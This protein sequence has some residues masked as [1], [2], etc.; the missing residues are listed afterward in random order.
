MKENVNEKNPLLVTV[1]E[2][3]GIPSSAIIK[4]IDKLESKGH[5]IHSFIMV[6]NGKIAAEGY[7]KP[8]SPDRKHR[9]YSISKSFVS[10][11][12]GLM[13]EEGLLSLDDRIVSF[14]PGKL[15]ADGV[16][17]YIEKM[18][19]RDLLRM[20]SA[21]EK[22]TY[23]IMKNDDWLKTFFTVKPSHLPGTVF[24]YDTSAAHT[25]GAIVEQLSGMTI[26]DYMRSRFLDFIGFSEDA[27][28]LKCPMGISQGGS[29]LVCT[30]RDI[31]K[32]ALTCMHNGQFDGRQLIPEK[33]IKAAT[34]RQIDSNVSNRYIE[35]QQGYGYLFWRCRNNGFV[36]LGMGGQLAICLPDKDFILVTTADT[37]S[38]SDEYSIFFD[39][40]WDEIYPYLSEE[41]ISTDNTKYNELRK[42]LESL[43][44]PVVKGAKSTTITTDVTNC[45]YGFSDNEL[46]LSWVRFSFHGDR[47]VFEYIN[48]EGK[49]ELN[50]GLGIHISQKFPEINYNCIT[51]AAWTDD[52]SLLIY[53]YIIDDCLATLKIN[54]IFTDDSITIYMSKF[55]E[56]FLEN[57]SGC[58]SGE[59]L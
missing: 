54:V 29:G 42:K 21:H 28:F 11:A 7:W 41:S 17:P 3:V 32:F 51:S 2:E 19:I 4:F 18:K 56:Q 27:F 31:A 53:S 34:S 10:V 57:Y 44:I 40:L 26:L 38:N 43:E 16:H 50:F 6:R 58:A 45:E 36:C 48:R 8:F 25:L 46:G 59:M 23:K 9:M 55:A 30:S 14:F 37:Q 5:C 22:T 12:I 47:G 35:C 24:S 49:Y 15:P 1:P 13:E 33:Y 52:N 39:A 20:A